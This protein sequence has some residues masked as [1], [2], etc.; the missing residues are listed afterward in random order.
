MPRGSFGWYF[1]DDL[2]A[3]ASATDAEVG[4]L[5][6][7]QHVERRRDVVVRDVRRRHAAADVGEVAEQLRCRRRRAPAGTIGVFSSAS[8]ESI[9]YC[10][11]CTA[12][13]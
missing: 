12:T 11:V 5:H 4:A 1:V 7:Q 6:A 3:R 13:L 10:G 8:I 2:V 9:R